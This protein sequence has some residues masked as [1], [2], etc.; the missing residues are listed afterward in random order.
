MQI[1]PMCEEHRVKGIN[2]YVG[3]TKRNLNI[4]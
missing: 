1:N 3:S 2:S 4:I